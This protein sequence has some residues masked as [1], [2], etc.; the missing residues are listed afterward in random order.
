MIIHILLIAHFLADFTFQTT[1]F[2]QRKLVNSNYFI[3]HALTYAV[4]FLPV[5]TDCGDCEMVL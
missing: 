3:Y 1:K 4:V 5:D 2:A